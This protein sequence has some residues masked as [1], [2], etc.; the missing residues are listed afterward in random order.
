MF[1][2]KEYTDNYVEMKCIKWLLSITV[3]NLSKEMG[4][5]AEYLT[6][7]FSRVSCNKKKF[8]D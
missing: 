2:L 6:P 7:L 5:R 3:L 4:N 1:F 8:T